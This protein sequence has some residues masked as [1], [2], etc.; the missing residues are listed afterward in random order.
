MEYVCLDC[1]TTWPVRRI[2]ITLGYRRCPKC[3]SYDTA[4]ANFWQMVEVGRQRGIS[5]NTPILDV[6]DAFQA[7]GG[8]G[9][10]SEFGFC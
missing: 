9:K 10:P 4:P 2:D 5:H 6:I 3:R 7:V 8:E 1:G